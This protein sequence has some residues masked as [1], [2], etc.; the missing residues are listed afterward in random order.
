MIAPA[1][2]LVALSSVLA[3]EPVP[4]AGAVQDAILSAVGAF[5]ASHAASR[6]SHARA[7]GAAGAGQAPFAAQMACYRGMG[8]TT[9]LVAGEP[10]A[11]L[12]GRLSGREGTFLFTARA[13]SYHEK[14]G[15][16]RAV[17]SVA[18][19]NAA[20]VAEARSRLAAD[21]GGFEMSPCARLA[22]PAPVHD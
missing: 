10:R 6:Q 19:L 1:A 15:A 3:A 16:V 8:G 18:S 22:A 14:E 17:G 11:R 20:L 21:P 12:S 5:H 9:E 7:R 4:G 13:A 2:L